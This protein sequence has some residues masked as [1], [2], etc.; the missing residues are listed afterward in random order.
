MDGSARSKDTFGGS[1][2]ERIARSKTTHD[3]A[4]RRG[5]YR[6]MRRRGGGALGGWRLA[7]PSG[8]FALIIA[9]GALL[10]LGAGAALAFFTEDLPTPQDLARDPLPQSTKVYDRT[11]TQL[12]YQFSEENR[13]LVGYEEIPQVLIDA[14]VAAEDKSFWSNPGVDV[15]GI[16][17]AVFADVTGRSSGQGGASTITQQLVKQRIVGSEVSLKRKIR[18]AI[19][20]IKVTNT[21][22]KQQILELYFNQIYYGNQAYGVKAAAQT[23]F[24]KT[25]LSKLTL[26]EA[27]LLAGLPQAPS[28]LD[29]T[30]ADKVD[31]A[32]RR[33][34]YVL[35]QM[36]DT[37]AIKQTAA[38]A[39]NNE[40]IKVAG[41][42]VAIIKAPHFVFQVRNQLTQIL[43]GDEAAVSRGGYRVTT[44]LDMTKQEIGERQ[45]SE[46]V[47]RLHGRNVWNAALVSIDPQTGEVLTY[48]GSVDYNNRDDPRVQGQF[49]VAGIGLRQP[50]SSFKMFNYVTALKNG[51]TAATVVVD[52]RTDFGGKADPTRMSPAACGY[53]PENADLQY[54]GPVTMRQAIRESRNVPAVRFLAEYSGIE[55][56][57]QTAREMGITTDIDPSK[58]GL[59]LTLGAKEVHLVDMASAYGVLAN[60]GLR[61]TPTY[62]L[63]VEDSRGK[64]LWEQ[65]DYEQKRVLDAGIA[66]IMPDILKDTTQ[67][68]RDF[69]FGQWTNIGR[70]AALKTGTTDNL[71]DVYSVGYVPTLVTGV[72]MGNSNGDPMSS[73]NFNSA[74]GPGQLWRDYMKEVLAD[75]PASDW[76]RPA[77]VVSGTVVSAPGAFGGY[78]SGLAPSALSPFSSTEWFMKGTEPARVD[79]WFVAGCPQPD[80]TVKVSMKIND[81]RAPA[82]FQRYTDQWVRDAIAGKHTYNR[83][84]WNLVSPDP[85][86]TPSVTL[87]PVPTR[88]PGTTPTVPPPSFTLPPCPTPTKQP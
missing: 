9:T 87:T 33:R 34:A 3:H 59:S 21:Y 43:G 2:H 85:C 71:K 31:R 79:D 56:T 11:G 8:L 7:L 5:A 48:V 27:A 26:A 12:L 76:P 63:K 49:D 65:K 13:E 23:Y 20:A 58:I 41:P 18:E 1:Y 46:W 50:G 24:G 74:M 88:T 10:L 72:W 42:P 47:E 19:L 81:T 44:T 16:V 37:G 61:V 15:L 57:I 69:I 25:D 82:A 40:T 77:N 66:W 73:R 30:K 67:P 60:M 35:D 64:V 80:G 53:C 68:S 54:H 45:V 51:A 39:A 36:L 55:A 29:P 14:T 70:V 84:T 52:A 83:Y 4:L 28:V 75:T 32:Q 78:G 6:S 62:I 17:R 86:P 38:D 22:S